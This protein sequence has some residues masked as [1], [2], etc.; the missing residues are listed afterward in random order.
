MIW[1]VDVTLMILG[2]GLLVVA[3]ILAYLAA[4][5]EPDWTPLTAA[6]PQAFRIVK[7]LA[8]TGVVV[9]GLGALGY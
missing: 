7:P 5:Y 9:L 1:S 8:L 6:Q 2:S 4:S 3:G